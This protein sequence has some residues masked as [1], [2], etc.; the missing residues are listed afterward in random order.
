MN[1][2]PRL[3]PVPGDFT[4]AVLRLALDGGRRGQALPQVLVKEFEGARPRQF[5]GRFVVARRRVVVE[6]V[7]LAL[8]RVRRVRLLV[9]LE[10]RLVGRY[11]GVD[12]LVVARVVEQERR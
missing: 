10:R 8:L 3:R 5:G 6:A 2:S 4:G 12:P 7:L 11:P 1:M 9:R